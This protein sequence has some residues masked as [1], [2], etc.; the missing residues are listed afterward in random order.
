MFEKKELPKIINKLE[1]LA[2]EFSASS[3]NDDYDDLEKLNKLLHH[4]DEKFSLLVQSHF[5]EEIEQIHSVSYFKYFELIAEICLKND[6]RYLGEELVKYLI[7]NEWFLNIEKSNYEVLDLTIQIVIE[8]NLDSYVDI[9]SDAER[10]RLSY[11]GESFP[12]NVK[13]LELN[14]RLNILRI[15]HET[16]VYKLLDKTIRYGEKQDFIRK[17]NQIVSQIRSE[18]K[19]S[20]EKNRWC[21]LYTVQ[22]LEYGEETKCL[23]KN[24]PDN[25]E[26]FDEMLYK[27][28]NVLLFPALGKVSFEK[29]K[30][31]VLNEGKG[32]IEKPELE[33]WQDNKQIAKISV[34]NTFPAGKNCTF[35]LDKEKQINVSRNINPNG[36]KVELCLIFKKFDNTPFK[37]TR[38]EEISDFLEGLQ[39]SDLPDQNQLLKDIIDKLTKMLE[40]KS[41]KKIEDLHTDELTD[42]LRDK[43]YIAADQTRTGISKSNAGEVD[44]MI[45]KENGTPVSIIEAFRLHSFDKTN[46]ISHL[47][48][49]LHNYDTAGHEKNYI[50]VYAEN[51]DFYPLWRKYFSYIRNLNK[52]P[53]FKDGYPLQSF[54]DTKKQFSQKADIKVGL[55]KHEREGDIVK[56]Y[57]IFTNMYVSENLTSS[58]SGNQEK[59]ELPSQ[60][61]LFQ[62]N[63]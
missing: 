18:D 22:D 40:R 21:R 7:I 19:S 8:F 29:Q 46:I 48:K 27:H 37:L 59:N 16:Y 44:I 43:G 10:V 49:L 53:E 35:Y 63:S 1:T 57:H 25:A 2:E 54:E 39:V 42:W 11:K 34:N 26:D 17:Y 50:I 58:K 13:Q 61:D 5:F 28:Y 41:T 3:P 6:L 52:Q 32:C 55:A 60:S 20:L 56:V 36:S 31:T 30:I 62:G 51:K 23:F 9:D 45:R 15:L 14:K 33:I 24:Q 47:N 12:I 4:Y 38:Y